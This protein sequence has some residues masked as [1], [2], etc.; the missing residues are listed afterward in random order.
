M[1]GPPSK[2]EVALV[3]MNRTLGFQ[4]IAYSVIVALLGLL[5]Y[6]LAPAISLHACVAALAGG[7]LCFAWGIRARNGSSSKAP[8]L[9]TLI[10]LSFVLLSQAITGWLGGGA[11]VAGRAAAAGIITL[12]LVL[13]IGMLMRIAYAGVIF[14]SR[15]SPRRG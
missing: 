7:I 14:E 4:L 15:P 10:P 8:S 6:Y 2:D 3:A 13:S 12:A 9:L 11:P 1:V 5:S